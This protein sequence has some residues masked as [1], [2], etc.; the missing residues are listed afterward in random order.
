MS[1]LLDRRQFVLRGSVAAAAVAIASG[2]LSRI[3]FAA[4]NDEEVIPFLDAQPIKPNSAAVKWED[5][6][7]WITPAK[8]FF[9]VSHYPRPLVDAA[10]WKLQLSGLVNKPI[11][12]TLPQIKELSRK[13]VTAT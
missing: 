13:E 3:G 9:D 4:S 12:L 11:A 7:E 5:L 10:N 2:P 6:T 8:D 1:S